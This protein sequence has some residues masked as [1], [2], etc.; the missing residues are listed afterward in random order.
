LRIDASVRRLRNVGAWT[1]IASC[2][3]V[4]TL[5]AGLLIDH[6]RMLHPSGRRVSMSESSTPTTACMLL[7]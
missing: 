3:I 6:P 2:T 1:T 4:R 7:R 5:T